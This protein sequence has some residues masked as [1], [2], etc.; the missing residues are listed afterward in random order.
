MLIKKVLVMATC[1]LFSGAVFAANDGF[2]TGDLTGY[3]AGANSVVTVD[4]VFFNPN[5]SLL[6]APEGTYFAT[7]DSFGSENLSQYGGTTG[8]YLTKNLTLSAGQKFT[9]EYA[10]QTTDDAAHNDFAAFSINGSQL[11]LGSVAT[12]ETGFATFTFTATTAFS[13]V[14]TWLVANRSSTDGSSYLLLDNLK[15][16]SAT[17]P[18]PEPETYAMLLAG[19][20]LLGAARL[21]KQRNK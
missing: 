5:G 13:G 14:V 20:G 2:E 7:L 16:I 15:I 18:V 9:F 6:F 12:G 4:P 11:Q 1:A 19:L 10:F 3:T 8:S 21:R 17:T